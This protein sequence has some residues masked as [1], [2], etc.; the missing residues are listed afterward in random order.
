M[1]VMN[2]KVVKTMSLKKGANCV[3]NNLTKLNIIY[4]ISHLKIEINYL[5]LFINII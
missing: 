3:A 2:G 1:K 5:Y 4:T